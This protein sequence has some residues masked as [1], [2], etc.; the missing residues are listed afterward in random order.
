MSSD[1][2]GAGVGTGFVVAPGIVATNHHVIAN[3]INGAA[4]LVNQTKCYT[5]AGVIVADEENDVALISVPDLTAPSL[6]IKHSSP[7]LGEQISVMGNPKGFEGTFA[8]GLVSRI[9][10]KQIQFSAPTSS[11]SSGS[12]LLDDWGRVVGIVTSYYVEG[13][14]LNFAAPVAYLVRLMKQKAAPSTPLALWNTQPV[15]KSSI[16]LAPSEIIDGTAHD[17]FSTSVWNSLM[18]AGTKALD[19]GNTIDAERYF[20]SAVEEAGKAKE[21]TYQLAFGI[22]MLAWA[23]EKLS[24]YELARANYEKAIRLQLRA[25]LH[26]P[27]AELV[28]DYQRLASCCLKA[29]DTTSAINSSKLGLAIAE[30]CQLPEETK[31]DIMNI[32][33]SAYA[34]AGKKDQ[35]DALANTISEQTRAKQQQEWK[36]QQ[37]AT[38][39]VRLTNTG[40]AA[41]NSGDLQAARYHFEQ[42]LDNNP[43]YRPALENLSKLFRVAGTRL[44]KGELKMSYLHKALAVWPDP[45][46][47]AAL[48]AALIEFRRNPND[49]NQRLIVAKV[50][51]E[52]GDLI[53]EIVELQAAITLD[54]SHA[55]AHALLGR[56]LAQVGRH[57]SSE[58]EFAQAQSLGYR[59]LS[60][61]RMAP[62]AV[63]PLAPHYFSQLP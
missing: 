40:I 17:A 15:L 55:E 34:G 38:P 12:P 2:V 53:G 58:Q 1:G 62:H 24:K 50:A 39:E 36:A 47:S 32:L 23:E 16:P 33:Q 9:A 61:V 30:R 6:Q 18:D 35:A 48:C 59:Q 11:G 49:A 42:A 26:T 14:N 44:P 8:Q 10:D 29:G 21:I 52:K 5:I 60:K 3:K 57:Q 54:H 63:T 37:A 20:S 31:T 7:A 4:N 28:R 25:A 45:L 27:P 51:A 22:K 43:N 41:L 13:Q 56:A 19:S 46:A